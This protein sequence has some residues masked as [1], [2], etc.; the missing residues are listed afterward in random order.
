MQQFVGTVP[1][2]IATLQFVYVFCIHAPM[3]LVTDGLSVSS[4]NYSTATSKVG[5][6]MMPCWVTHIDLNGVFTG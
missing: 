5:F 1:A 2:F 6:L 3:A 4:K